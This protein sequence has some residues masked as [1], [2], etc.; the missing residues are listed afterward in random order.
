M[1][2]VLCMLLASCGGNKS[3]D[4]T[5]VQ[6][7]VTTP[8]CQHPSTATVNAKSADCTTDGYTGDQV[9]T[10]CYTVVTPGSSIP[11]TGHVRTKV[12]G[13]RPATCTATGYTG[14]KECT[15]CGTKVENGSEIA[16]TAHNYDSGMTTKV[17]TCMSTGV[18]TFMCDCGISYT[19]ELDVVAHYDE[20]HDMLDGTH[21]HTCATCTMNNNEAHTPVD[22][23]RYVEATCEERA[24]T[25]LTCS[26]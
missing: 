13:A 15:T 19:E 3:K 2:L 14:D 17:P 18:K 22:A 7:T 8:G 23:G 26:V 6:P 16:I 20:Y 12:T 5:P 1:H 21:N 25:E 4:D 24:Y 10:A 11:A 9:C